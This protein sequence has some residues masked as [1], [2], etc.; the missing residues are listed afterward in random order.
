MKL[1]HSIRT[2]AITLVASV[3]LTQLAPAA[4]EKVE[5]TYPLKPDGHVRLSNVNGRI[6]VRAWDGAGVKL[7]AV[8]E[9]RTP[10]IVAGIKI[11][12]DTTPGRL[13][14]K[15][16]LAKVKRGW[17]RGTSYEGQ[18]NYVLSVP[19]G[20]TLERIE[21]VNGSV[22]V[23][24][25]RGPVHAA[26]VNGGI[27]CSTLAGSAVLE[28]VNG[29]I[30]SEHATLADGERLQASSVNG[31]VEVRLPA[32]LSAALEASTVNGTIR[33]EFAFTTTT[34]D[35]RRRV[36]ARIRDG[37]ARIELSTVNGGIRV[38]EWQI[39]QASAR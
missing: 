9:G 4:S 13:I 23:E 1:D 21:S 12:A 29:S 16:E 38:R 35:S 18:V 15:T 28:T 6:E 36:E 2:L 34:R 8:K 27:R 32:A 26:T 30:R 14:I 11:V 24:G 5:A 10:E 17:L 33:S 31:D 7:E 3:L 39:E 25:M 19:A 20:A 37:G 22:G